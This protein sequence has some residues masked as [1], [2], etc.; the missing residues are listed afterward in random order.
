MACSR[1]LRRFTG[2]TGSL[3]GGGRARSRVCATWIGAGT[4]GAR[5]GAVGEDA[6][7]ASSSGVQALRLFFTPR[8][9]STG[10]AASTVIFALVASSSDEKQRR[11]WHILLGCNRQVLT[12]SASVVR[13]VTVWRMV[14]SGGNGLLVSIDSSFSKLVGVG[15][16]GVQ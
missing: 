16:R 9:A 15:S 12:G 13:F 11:G 10:R 7:A 3:H 2:S 1:S 6:C 5:S 4:C 14:R 8:D